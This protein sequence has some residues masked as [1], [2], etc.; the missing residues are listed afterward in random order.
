LHPLPALRDP[1]SFPTRRSSDLPG[2]QGPN[3]LPN[4]RAASI[5]VRRA[6]WPVP[7]WGRP[8]SPKVASIGKR[9]APGPAV[10]GASSVGRRPPPRVRSVGRR[11]RRNGFVPGSASPIPTPSRK[12]RRTRPFE[13]DVPRLLPRAQVHRDLHL[14]VAHV[15]AVPQ[16]VAEARLAPLVGREHARPQPPAEDRERVH[17]RAAR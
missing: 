5:P 7:L 16:R 2:T 13:A 3:G 17:G 12:T 4:S 1:P 6:V 15:G 14:D 10:R 9:W 11:A 8:A